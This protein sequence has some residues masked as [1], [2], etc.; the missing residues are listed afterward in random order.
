MTY[1][2]T[3]TIATQFTAM[4]LQTTATRHERALH[5]KIDALIRA[6]EP[7]DNRLRGI[8]EACEPGEFPHG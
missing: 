7:A 8:E 5:L 2:T 1:T 6:I 4:L 3:L